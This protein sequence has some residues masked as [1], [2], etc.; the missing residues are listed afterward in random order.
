[1]TVFL[2]NLRCGTKRPSAIAVGLLLS[3]SMLL[4][5][6]PAGAE[7]DGIPATAA[8]PGPTPASTS[9]KAAAP[10]TRLDAV[11]CNANLRKIT[12]AFLQTN[13]ELEACRE[14]EELNKRTNINFLRELEA[15][16]DEITRLEQRLRKFDILPEEG[17]AYL[18]NNHDSFVAH[19]Q[20]RSRLGDNPRLNGDECGKALDWLET[21]QDDRKPYAR[22][23]WV[24]QQ[25]AV[26]VC[27]R[28]AESGTVIDL[29]R[30]GDEAHILVL[31]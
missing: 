24:W 7:T 12:G 6:K 22:A 26:R 20:L 2:N 16:R 3:L 21:Q 5:P 25:G 1:M 17:F 9:E 30:P 15:A 13:N 4:S 8:G 28:A 10:N 31:R 18:G 23:V 19:F 29:P 11:S 14:Q 27:R